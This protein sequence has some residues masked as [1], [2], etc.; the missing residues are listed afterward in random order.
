VATQVVL[1]LQLPFAIVPLV[2]F[3]ADRRIMGRHASPWWLVGV[4]VVAA[5]L[6][7]GCNAWLVV[8]ALGDQ[9][10]G[11]AFAVAGA[12]AAA[13]LALLI[14]LALAPLQAA[15]PA[16]PDAPSRG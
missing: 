6:V 5:V 9:L 13:G 11:I 4:A 7:I 2:R 3:T 10:A 1:S 8:Q 16:V 14:Y 12:L 15:R